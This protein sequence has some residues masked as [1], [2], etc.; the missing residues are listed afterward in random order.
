M[1]FTPRDELE[2]LAVERARAEWARCDSCHEPIDPDVEGPTRVRHRGCPPPPV[3]ALDAIR[4][5][6]RERV[7]A[8]RVTS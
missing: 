1:A 3:P 5:R 2:R 6:L 4:A 8:R 7:A